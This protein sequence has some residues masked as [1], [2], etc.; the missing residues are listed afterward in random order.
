M[1]EQLVYNE[2]NGSLSI[3][4]YRPSSYSASFFDKFS[5]FSWII[6]KTAKLSS[7]WAAAKFIKIYGYLIGPQQSIDCEKAILA[8]R[9]IKFL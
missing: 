4:Q 1:T 8:N 6:S 7:R 2:V 9:E 3:E 5:R